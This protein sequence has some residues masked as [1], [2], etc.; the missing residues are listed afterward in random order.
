M[1]KLY[2]NYQ[3]SFLDI[4]GALIDFDGTL[5]DSIGAWQGIEDHLVSISHGEVTKEDRAV[6]TTMTIPEIGQF[7]HEKFGIGRDSA[8]V[9]S[10][11]DEY[12]VDYYATKATL[13]PGVATF[14]EAAA[15]GGI[16]MSIVSSS[17]QRFLQAGVANT[18]IG[19]YFKEIISVDDLNTTKRSPKIYNHAHELLQTPKEITWGFEDSLYALNA[20]TQGGFKTVGIFDPHEGKTLEYWREVTTVSVDSLAQLGVM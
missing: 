8:S 3:N 20:L 9:V 19:D 1:A 15:C 4:A 17:P 18:G 10:I 6:L 13:L 12:M 2:V 5:I 11:I 14:L 7:F 16:V